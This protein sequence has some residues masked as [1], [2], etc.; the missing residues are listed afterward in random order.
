MTPAKVG[1]ETTYANALPVQSAL[2]R[3]NYR[4]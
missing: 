2:H 3:E 4:P 1:P